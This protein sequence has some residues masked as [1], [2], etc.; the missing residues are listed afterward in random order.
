MK[1]GTK[2]RDRITGTTGIVDAR[3]VYLYGSPQ[4]RVTPAETKDCH[5]AEG[6]WL[7]ERRVEVCDN[8]PPL[9]G[10]GDRTT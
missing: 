7:E 1:L 8:A 10:F 3:T 5:P 6:F 9:V 4:V 2:V